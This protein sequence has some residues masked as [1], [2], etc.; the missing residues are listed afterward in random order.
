MAA[1]CEATLRQHLPSGEG[2]VQ[3]LLFRLRDELG[4]ARQHSCGANLVDALARVGV[5]VEK[6]ERQDQCEAD[7]RLSTIFHP[8]LLHTA[9]PALPSRG[10]PRVA[11][12]ID[13]WSPPSRPVCQREAPH[14]SRYGSGISD[15]DELRMQMEILR[16]HLAGFDLSVDEALDTLCASLRQPHTHGSELCDHIALA[17]GD[18]GLRFQPVMKSWRLPRDGV[19]LIAEPNALVRAY[20]SLAFYEPERFMHVPVVDRPERAGKEVTQGLLF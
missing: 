16:Q 8:A 18:V 7:C 2:S 1:F 20:P 6:I 11:F 15:R 17:L 10:S 5:V 3:A 19:L 14:Q 12:R 4:P 9:F 13:D